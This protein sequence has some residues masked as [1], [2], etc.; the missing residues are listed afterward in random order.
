[1]PHASGGSSHGLHPGSTDVHSLPPGNQNS[2]PL[3]HPWTPARR[4]AFRFVFALV[5]ISAARLINYA[6][7]YVVVA[8]LKRPIAAVLDA[9]FYAQL[10]LLSGSGTFVIGIGRATR[11]AT[12]F[13]EYLTGLIILALGIALSWTALD[14]RRTQYVFLERWMRIYVRYQLASAIFIYGMLKVLPAQFGWFR[15]S[16]LLQ[17]VGNLSSQRLLWMFMAFSPAY[18]VFTGLLESLG[19]LAVLF[20]RTTVFGSLLLAGALTNVVA[21][22]L[23]YGVEPEALFSAVLLLLFCVVLLAPHVSTLI[24]FLIFR[25]A[26]PLLLDGAAQGVPP[27]FAQVCKGM[28]AVLLI[29][30]PLHESFTRRKSFFGIGHEVYGLYEVEGFRHLGATLGVSRPDS[31]RWRRIATDGDAWV[32]V[33]TM[34]AQVGKYRI[35]DG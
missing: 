24:N 12:G 4:F 15:P 20:R 35:H 11:S 13:V 27:R 21:L 19:G 3:S 23:A 9:I 17:P 25:R 29:T 33:L 8:A 22:D 5:V 10:D 18:T 2:P 16:Y 26:R 30:V 7:F 32:V 31:L 6:E 28:V 14:R 1:M 34:D